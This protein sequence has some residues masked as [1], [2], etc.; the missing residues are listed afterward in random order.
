MSLTDKD[1]RKVFCEFTQEIAQPVK[2]RSQSPLALEIDRAEQ[3]KKSGFLGI[4]L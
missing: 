4:A 1:S 2:V 3:I